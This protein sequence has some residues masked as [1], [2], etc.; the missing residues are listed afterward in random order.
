MP[1]TARDIYRK[2]QKERAKN[3]VSS[4]PE[5]G[6]IPLPAEYCQKNRY[7]P[8]AITEQ[9]GW[10]NPE[11]VPHLVE[12]LNALHPDDPCNF[13]SVWFS[14]QSAKTTS[15][16]ENAILFWMANKL[17]SAIA[18]SASKG[19]QK[20]KSNTSIDLLIDNSPLKDMVGAASTRR[21]RSTG[22]TDLFKQFAGGGKLKLTSYRSL[23]DLVGQTYNMIIADER[24]KAN[25]EVTIGDLGS[26]I[27]S[28]T[29]AVQMWKF[30]EAST[31]SNFGKSHIAA[32][33]YRGDQR[34]RFVP[35][36]ICGEMQVLVFRLGDMEHGLTFDMKIDDE[37]GK[38][39]LDENSVRYVCEHCHRP[40]YESQKQII[41]NRG[42]WRPTWQDPFW[43]PQGK[44]PRGK[45]RKSYWAN[46]LISKYLSWNRICQSYIDTSFGKDILKYKT[47]CIDILTIEW[48]HVEK[49]GSFEKLKDRA[50]PW[51]LGS[52]ILPDNCG[53]IIGGSVDVQGDRLELGIFAVDYM[54]ETHFI[55]HIIFYGNPADINDRST[56]GALHDF[57]YRKEYSNESGITFPIEK[58]AIDTG[59]DPN[60]KNNRG[61][62]KDFAGKSHTVMQFIALRQDKFVAIKGA[63]EKA[64]LTGVVTEKRVRAGALTKVYHFDTSLIKDIFFGSI[65]NESGPYALHLPKYRKTGMIEEPISE[66][67]YKQIMSER[68][69]E[70]KPGVMGWKKI[71]E[72]NELLDLVVYFWGLCYMDNLHQL[73]F[74]WWQETK[75]NLATI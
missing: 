44:K 38:K 50:E 6:Y 15:F 8:R 27:E 16:L 53:P 37:T 54:L 33:F 57:A 71:H 5:S 7:L 34:R 39:I 31:G 58:I 55:D 65:E 19:L 12:P 4:L 70:I 32:S 64:G 20:D 40:F 11:D 66:S 10:W 74:E 67:W 68:K 22:D 43:N 51:C 30:L 47:F 29:M 61:Q 60:D 41:N 26:M 18:L 56:W 36:P 24:D 28:R 23:D 2:S 69:Q 73:D 42:E 35:C 72:R 21:K 1:I 45:N 63:G 13:I 17:G 62:K 3:A 52:D 49:Q 59:Y 9:P 48:A 14:A 46:G 25:E 75:E